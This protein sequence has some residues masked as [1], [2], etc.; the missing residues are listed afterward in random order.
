MGNVDPRI[1]LEY[2]ALLPL[3]RMNRIFISSPALKELTLGMG[4]LA[5]HKVGVPDVYSC[6]I[7]YICVYRCHKNTAEIG[8]FSRLFIHNL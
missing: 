7:I 5:R 1:P 3:S 6:R 2:E 8:G 4:R